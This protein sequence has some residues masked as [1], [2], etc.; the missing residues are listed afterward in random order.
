MEEAPGLG[1]RDI[2]MMCVQRGAC[3]A[4]MCFVVACFEG[5]VAGG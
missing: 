5:E 3:G 1:R 2:Q 4:A